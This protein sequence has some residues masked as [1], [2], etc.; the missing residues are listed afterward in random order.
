MTI[1]DSLLKKDELITR[2]GLLCLEEKNVEYSPDEKKI[3]KMGKDPKQA[4]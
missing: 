3:L 1:G 4:R 2:M